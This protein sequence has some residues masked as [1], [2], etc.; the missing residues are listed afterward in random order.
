MEVLID[1][2]YRSSCW[3]ASLRLRLGRNGGSGFN[4]EVRADSL[5]TEGSLLFRGNFEVATDSF[6]LQADEATCTQTRA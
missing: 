2:A 5:E 6:L 1:E 4:V 3:P